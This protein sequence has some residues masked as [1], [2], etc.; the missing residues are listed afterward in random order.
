LPFI[1]GYAPVATGA[2]STGDPS[3]AYRQQR[4]F[5]FLSWAANSSLS[6]PA[7]VAMV[8]ALGRPGE[9]GRR[10]NEDN[11]VPQSIK[12]CFLAGSAAALPCAALSTVPQC[13]FH[14][15]ATPSLRRNWSAGQAPAER[16]GT[17]FLF[18]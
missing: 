8:A 18:F 10:R 1:V 15:Q 17:V 16:T 5:S 13:W 11:V 14:N 6:I 2:W 9:E 7:A 12:L 4:L 3:A